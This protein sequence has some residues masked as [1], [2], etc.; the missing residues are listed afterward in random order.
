MISSKNGNA[1][2]KPFTNLDIEVAVQ[3]CSLEKGF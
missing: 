2:G 1:L 3:R